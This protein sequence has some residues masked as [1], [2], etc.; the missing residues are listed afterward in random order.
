MPRPATCGYGRLNI[1]L[2]LHPGADAA[3]NTAGRYDLHPLEKRWAKVIV[4]HDIHPIVPRTSSP[5]LTAHQQNSVKITAC[6]KCAFVS[7]CV[8]ISIDARMADAA[9][10]TE[11]NLVVRR[12]EM[13]VLHR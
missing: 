4:G 6:R 9:R 5:I 3:P 2:G 8:R 7:G 13:V 10:V 1:A 11:R 12:A